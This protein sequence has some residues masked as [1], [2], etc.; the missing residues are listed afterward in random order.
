MEKNS[1]GRMAV[2]RITLHPAVKFS[3]EKVPTREELVRLHHEAHDSCFIANS[4][5]TEIR[6]EPR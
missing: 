4:V 3:G 1:E 2:T 5:K 6:C